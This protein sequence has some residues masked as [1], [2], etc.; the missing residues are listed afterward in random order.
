MQIVDGP[1]LVFPFDRA[2]GGDDGDAMGRVIGDQQP[3]RGFFAPRE[4]R[5]C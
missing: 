4:E 2:V 1:D 5:K 3:M